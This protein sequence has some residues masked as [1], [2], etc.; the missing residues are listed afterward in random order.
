MSITIR[1]FTPE[2]YPGLAA[3]ATAIEPDYPETPEHLRVNDENRD[4]AAKFQRFIAVK[5]GEVI[6]CAGYEDHPRGSDR[7]W[8]WVEVH[9]AHQKQGYGNALYEYLLETLKPFD[10]PILRSDS[11]E[12]RERGRQFL[13]DRGF[14][15]EMREKESA[16]TVAEFDPA[17]FQ[18][19]VER[20]Q[21]QS[22]VFKTY[23]QL[24][25]EAT[26]LADLHQRLDDLHWA[27]DQDIP[28]PDE[29]VRRP[30]SEFIKRFEHPSFQPEGNIYALD[31]E[32]LIGGSILWGRP[33][34]KDLDTGMT[35]VLRDYRKRGIATALKVIAL[36]YAK[37]YGATKVRTQN[38]ENNVGMLGIN[39]RLGF[40]PQPAWI[41]YV[42]ELKPGSLKIE[43]TTATAP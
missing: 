3:I 15:E 1:P 19:D 13:L 41:F 16:L 7:F 20:A 31:G 4:P 11:R 33:T 37:K 29:H 38:E 14:V 18:A 25:A 12:N 43:K 22:I 23:A 35:G 34:G 42:K 32:R 24:R 27:V 30:H 28:F 9:P 17:V 36:T 8:I 21:A 26:D 5:D 40:K 2:D 39:I 6:G 10:P